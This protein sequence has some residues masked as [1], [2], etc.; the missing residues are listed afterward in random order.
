MK[1][2]G[3]NPAREAFQK[4]MQGTDW[5]V[6]LFGD[7]V[8]L[9]LHAARAGDAEALIKAIE[10]GETL[11]AAERAWAGKHM[12][13]VARVSRRKLDQRIREYKVVFLVRQYMQQGMTEYAAI[14]CILERHQ[15]MFSDPEKD[16]E[17]AMKRE[18]IE[19]YL[20]KWKKRN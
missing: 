13:G 17:P 16:A 4:T 9:R 5:S 10:A 18:T 7:G 20:K 11:D 6:G 8:S 14:N 2:P 1:K 15:D 3:P 19:T 12:R